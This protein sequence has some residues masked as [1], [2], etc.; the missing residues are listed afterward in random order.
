MAIPRAQASTIGTGTSR[1][2]ALVLAF[3]LFPITLFALT[4]VT[5]RIIVGELDPL[6]AGLVRTAGAIVVT[7]P[8]ALAL[9]FAL[10]R[11]AQGWRLLL[12]NAG[13]TFTLFP[14]L[15]AL[16]GQYTSASHAALIMASTPIIPGLCVAVLE[17]RRPRGTW[18]LGCAIAFAGEAVLILLRDPGH[19]GGASALGD[20]LIFCACIGSGTGYVASARLSQ[21]IGVWAG[22]FWSVTL[23][24]LVQIPPIALLWPR[25]NWAAVDAAGWA[26]LVHLTYGA[27]VIA[28]LAWTWALARGG[29]ARVAV[30][31]FAQP[32]IGVAL[33]A[34]LL[35]E[36][37]TAPLL[38]AA[39][40]ILAGVVIARRR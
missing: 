24:S 25:A 1:D 32:I 11:D 23:A 2:A 31:Q 14:V 17:R 21:R 33:A 28:I 8:L 37:I 10:P 36:R 4:P 3:A 6:F 35:G 13:L 40:F 18:W 12:L 16:G 34:L 15:F 7:L 29:V 5:M 38:V 26:A 19:A 22:I 20:L 39:A 27:T 9:R 30:L